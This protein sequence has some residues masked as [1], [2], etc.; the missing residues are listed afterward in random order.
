MRAI[1]LTIYPIVVIILV[2]L[3]SADHLRDLNRVEPSARDNSDGT[4]LARPSRWIASLLKEYFHDIDW[5]SIELAREQVEKFIRRLDRL[6]SFAWLDHGL[7]QTTSNETRNTDEQAAR[8]TVLSTL[9]GSHSDLGRQDE[10]QNKSTTTEPNINRWWWAGQKPQQQ[11]AG[12]SASSIR[13]ALDRVACFVGYMRL[14]NES[15]Q[16]LAELDSSKVITNLLAA[17]TKKGGWLS[18]WFGWDPASRFYQSI[19]EK[20][21][22]PVGLCTLARRHKT[23]AGRAA[24]KRAVKLTDWPPN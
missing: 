18:S 7:N 9:M 19:G 24:S 16:M 6:L 10:D 3:A 20:S 17:S 23:R 1:S 12:T 11:Q 5:R 2:S 14:L 13:D 22:P 8:F 21:F 15:Q 4:S